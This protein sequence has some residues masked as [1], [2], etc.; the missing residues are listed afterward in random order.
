MKKIVILTGLFF[1]F[2]FPS[3]ASAHILS[4]DG[5][6]GAVIHIDPDDDPIAGEQ[7]GFFF[8]F[9]DKQNKFNPQ[10]CE[11][12]FTILEGGK[13]LYAQPLFRDNTSPSLTSASVSYTFPIKDVYKIQVTGKPT[14]P[15][16]FQ[17]FTLTYDIRVE[18]E[19]DNK[20]PTEQTW[21]STHVH[22]IRTTGIIAF[23]VIILGIYLIK[24]R[25][26]GGEN[27]DEK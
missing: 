15:D 9:K 16:A 2:T 6:I 23:F 14:S 11:C 4:T 21:L 3:Q 13:E 18:R 1:A 26:N 5:N 17:P 12:R 25:K 7:T 19:S 10:Q 8:E 22:H 24:H 20:T 27:K